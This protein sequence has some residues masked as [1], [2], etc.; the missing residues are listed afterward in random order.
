[1]PASH[2]DE[3]ERT[4][5]KLTD[6]KREYEDKNY[7]LSW[8]RDDDVTST[9]NDLCWYWDRRSYVHETVYTVRDGY[10]VSKKKHVRMTVGVHI[11]VNAIT[12][13]PKAMKNATRIIPRRRPRPAT[14]QVLIVKM[15]VT[16]LSALGKGKQVLGVDLLSARPMHSS[17]MAREDVGVQNGFV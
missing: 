3:L 2:I 9:R 4:D 5:K 6:V 14:A 13:T 15:T 7:G 16:H 12:G 10:T 17:I 1:M 8:V 11:T